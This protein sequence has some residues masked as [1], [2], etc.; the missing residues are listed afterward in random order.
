MELGHELANRGCDVVGEGEG[1]RL[2]YHRLCSAHFLCQG[3]LI[4]YDEAALHVL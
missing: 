4:I 3:F 2:L 1:I